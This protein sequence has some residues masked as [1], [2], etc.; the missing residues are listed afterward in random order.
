MIAQQN[1]RLTT[2]SPFINKIL[3]G[4]SEMKK[5]FGLIMNFILATGV[6]SQYFEPT[7][8]LQFEKINIEKS[9]IS[10]KIAATK[11]LFTISDIDELKLQIRKN[12]NAVDNKISVIKNQLT[13]VFM[14]KQELLKLVDIKKMEEQITVKEKSRGEIKGQIQQDLANIVYQ[15]L[16]L[17]LLNDVDPFASKEQLS[18]QAEKLLAPQAIEDL[19]GVFISSLTE[20]QD[21]K[22][23]FDQIKATISG[24]MGIEKQFISKTIANRTKFLYLAKINVAPLKKALAATKPAASSVVK[25]LLVNFLNEPNYQTKLQQVGIPAEDIKN[26]NFEVSSSLEVINTSNSTASR[27][28]QQIM[29]LGNANLKK[30]DDEIVELKNN[31]TNRSVL[32]KETIEKKTDVVY[33]TSDMSGSINKAMSY[34]DKKIKGLQDDLIATKEK[35][36]VIKDLVNV[37]AEGKP[38][39]DI[40]KTALDICGQIKLSYSKVEQFISE[41]EVV[42]YQLVSDKTGSAKDIFREVDKIWLYPIAGSSDNFLLTVVAKFKITGIKE[43]LP[44][45]TSAKKAQEPTPEYSD[46]VFV[47]G[48]TFRMRINDRYSNEKLVHSVTVSNFYISKTEVTVA[49]YR[50]FCQAIGRQMP[51]APRWGWQEN[52]PIVN[53]TWNDAMEFCQWAGCRLPTEAEWEYAARGGN[54]SENYAYS[55]SN[56]A[57]DVAWHNI[58]SGDRTHLVGTK[59]SNELGLYDM[60][61]NV[62]EW[63]SE[64][65][66]C[67]GSWNDDADVCMAAERIRNYPSP[68]IY[69]IGFRVVQDSP[70]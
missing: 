60:S 40:A 1:L 66:L 3:L 10:R 47:A 32:L 17:V 46:M 54:K 20:V 39:E 4:N 43:P 35:D 48:G 8:P 24:E 28:Q 70:Q 23:L 34:F 57:E 49:Q 14:D 59:Q 63:C 61:G 58:N 64:C 68:R 7:S 26:I 45:P 6:F 9:T 37:T 51:L 33:Q 56:N 16:Y 41:T 65:V 30:V 31:L 2:S 50:A 27:R 15:G 21:N 13:N 62:W 29:S 36:L 55:G 19:N 44:T 38:E 11:I 18:A 42:N 5:S 53:V 12:N 67:G 69:S 25:H 22:L 52:H